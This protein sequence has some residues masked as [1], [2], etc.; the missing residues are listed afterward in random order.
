MASRAQDM[1]EQPLRAVS[2][3]SGA[4]SDS[5]PTAAGGGAA[6]SPRPTVAAQWRPTPASICALLARRTFSFGLEGADR[7]YLPG[8]YAT[9]AASAVATLLLVFLAHD[10]VAPILF[11][12]TVCMSLLVQ[13][14]RAVSDLLNDP[15]SAG[16]LQAEGRTRRAS[17]GPG[18]EGRIPVIG[19]RVIMVNSNDAAFLGHVN[20]MMSDRD[21]TS[22]DYERLLALDDAPSA[23]SAL[24][25]AAAEELSVLPSYVFKPARRRESV[26]TGSADGTAAAA[27][28]PPQTTQ[29]ARAEAAA[30]AAQARAAGA[31]ASTIRR[32]SSRAALAADGAP[33]AAT[34]TA[35]ATNGGDS[36]KSTT[37]GSGGAGSATAETR[38]VGPD[39]DSGY[40]SSNCT[41]SICLEQYQEGEHLRM[42]PCM[43]AFHMDCVD[44]WLVVRATCPVCKSSIRDPI[45][46]MQ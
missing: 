8:I 44:T 9:I 35:T 16:Y 30:A 28:V 18:A 19:R 25:G 17:S 15:R 31:S 46:R 6:T 1:E 43:H 34:P 10:R 12:V 2:V 29:R 3:G 33:L 22:N 20:L 23:T 45:W 13:C 4:S 41:C 42:L 26:G 11:A 14:I 38:T 37:G 40:S 7:R 24:A 32:A 5:S 27:P 39:A 36:S 21:F